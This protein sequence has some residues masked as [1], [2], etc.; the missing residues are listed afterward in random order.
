MEGQWAT[1]VEIDD[2]RVKLLFEAN[3]FEALAILVHEVECVD[4]Q[5]R[6]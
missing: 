6:D 1:R 3:G 2:E 4:R 5:E